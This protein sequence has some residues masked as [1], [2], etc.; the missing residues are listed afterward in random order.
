M[1]T[2][3]T[4]WA[5]GL[6]FGECPRWREGR[7]WLSDFYDHAVK[8]IDSQG[9]VERV[10][11]VPGQPA[12]LGWLP[13]GR[14]LVVSML[15]RRVL[16]WEGGALVLHADLSGVAT[17]HA[18]DLVVDSAGRAYVGNFGFDLEGEL[19]RRGV[20]SVVAEHPRAR[21]ARVDPDGTTRAVGEPLSFP[22]GMALVDGERRLLVAET[23]AFRL[24]SFQVGPDG[25]SDRRTVAD[26]AAEGLAPDGI[27][28][29]ADGG[30]WLAD[31][32]APRCVRLDARGQITAVVETD[33]RCF[34]CVLGGEDGRT[35]FVTG[36]DSDDSHV[37][38]AS[39]GSRVWS[40][41]VEIPALR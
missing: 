29:D 18:N 22:N 33:A 5:D 38:S 32:L 25:L 11:E 14:M 6:R 10:L 26:L 27:C 20:P 41:R 13:D 19:E 4:L 2:R 17:F 24:A 3:A 1:H 9:R 23:I 7:L 12:G 36:A 30:V 16:R 34:G 39:W 37:A 15:D 21:L 8:T 35:L 28:P 31:A 40:A